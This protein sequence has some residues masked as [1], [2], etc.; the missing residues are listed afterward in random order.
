VTCQA[1]VLCLVILS[2]F[3]FWVE[4]MSPRYLEI[5][6]LVRLDKDEARMAL[7]GG[8]GLEQVD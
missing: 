3:P 2:I 4:G 6:G 1:L 5:G 7:G 8:R